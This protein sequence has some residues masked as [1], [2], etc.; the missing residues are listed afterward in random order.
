MNITHFN[1]ADNKLQKNK[2]N[3]FT[4]LITKLDN[5]ELWIKKMSGFFPLKYKYQRGNFDNSAIIKFVNQENK[6]RDQINFE[7]IS[8]AASTCYGS[9][10]EF[11]FELYHTGKFKFKCT[12]NCEKIGPGSGSGSY[13]GS[14]SKQEMDRV[15]N[16]VSYFNLKNDSTVFD[17]PIDADE[18]TLM[19]KVNKNVSYFKGNSNDFQLKMIELLNFIYKMI[20]NS[21]M[22]KTDSKLSFKVR[23]Y[24]LPTE[25]I[26]Q[27][28]PPVVN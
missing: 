19:V 14:F 21:K 16:L 17:T 27:F 11:N 7:Y 10:P 8:I 5:N 22:V 9:C 24:E 3:I 15:I 23:S 1:S 18:T 12:S 6:K 2:T 28:L 4:G 26:I 20:E 25:K 13:T